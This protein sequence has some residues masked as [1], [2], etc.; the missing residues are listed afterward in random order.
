M[1]IRDFDTRNSFINFSI[2][3]EYF[4]IIVNRVL[5]IM[6]LSQIT[7]VPNASDY[8]KGILNFR[9]AIVPV[10]DL[11]R[12]FNFDQF[13]GKADMVIV[14]EVVYKDSQVLMGLLVDEVMDVIEFQ[15]KDIRTVP[16]IGVKYNPEFL[17]GF[18]ERNGMLIMVLDV[19]RVLSLAELAEVSD[20]TEAGKPA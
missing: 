12:R 4:A 7:K 20:V 19:D 3:N 15:Y 8:V 13:A 5:E 9:G 11:P 6:H 17:E 2:G 10:I 14:V 16:E 18:I 1:K